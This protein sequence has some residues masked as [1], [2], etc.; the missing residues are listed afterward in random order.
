MMIDLVTAVYK[1]EHMLAICLQILKIAGLD[2]AE[3]EA[4]D[5]VLFYHRGIFL[6]L[7]VLV[8]KHNT[9]L[10]TYSFLE[11]RPLAELWAARLG[12]ITYVMG[13][14]R[15]EHLKFSKAPTLWHLW[16]LQDILEAVE[17]VITGQMIGKKAFI[18]GIREILKRIENRALDL[19]IPALGTLQPGA[20]LKALSISESVRLSQMD[21]DFCKSHKKYLHAERQYL[22]IVEKR[23]DLDFQVLGIQG[24]HFVSSRKGKRGFGPVK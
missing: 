17:G 4:I 19:S 22:K 14:K 16:M 13:S 8:L 23:S 11:C 12:L 15:S 2:G 7:K 3:K 10:Q 18:Q 9:D 24:N 1:V 21:D 6:W 5:T 20:K